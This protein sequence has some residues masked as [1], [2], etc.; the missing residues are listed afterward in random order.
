MNRIPGSIIAVETTDGMSLVEVA[1]PSHEVVTALV[2]DI[3]ATSPY[4]RAGGKV[5]VI[6]KET[7]VFLAKGTL[8]MLSVRSRF[9]AIVQN[10]QRGILLSE[11]T[12]DYWGHPIRALI[13]SKSRDAMEI[14]AGDRVFALVKSTEISLEEAP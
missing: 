4:L 7:E 3:P 10:V 14:Q 9:S 11:I 1:I 5:S 12:L 13:T 6:F 8:P 2:L